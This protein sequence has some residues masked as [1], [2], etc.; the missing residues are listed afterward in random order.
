MPAPTAT[1]ALLAATDRLLEQ[2]LAGVTE[3]APAFAACLRAYRRALAAGDIATADGLLAWLAGQPNVGARIKRAAGIKGDIDHYA[4]LGCLQGL[5]TILRD[6]GFRG[7]VFCDS[8]LRAEEL[9]TGLRRQAESAFAQARDCVIVATSTLELGL[10]V[11]DL[12]RVIQI[13]AQAT[14]SG[15]LQRLGRSGRRPGSTRNCLLL[16]TAGL[17]AALAQG[18]CGTAAGAARAL[19]SV[20]AATAEPDPAGTRPATRG[21]AAMAGTDTGLPARAGHGGAHRRSSARERPALERR[22]RAALRS[23]RRTPLQRAVS[24]GT[25]VGIR[26]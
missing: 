17:A 16:A 20:R 10:D 19:A 6:A 8:R 18:L 12:G 22:R 11:S 5:L 9:T 23:G 13:D 24:A 26:Q 7:L 14:V 4:A 3:R 21:L 15:F 25:A 1:P 2:R